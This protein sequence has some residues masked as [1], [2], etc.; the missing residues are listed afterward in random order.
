VSAQTS[1]RASPSPKESPSPRAFREDPS[2]TPPPPDYKAP[3]LLA[4][5]KGLA[6]LFATLGLAFALYCLRPHAGHARAARSP[7]AGSATADSAAPSAAALPPAAQR[8]S[9][10]ASTAATAATAPAAGATA[11]AG[12][13]AAT[14]GNSAATQPIY[15]EALP[16]NA[17]Q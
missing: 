7:A 5:H 1:T 15:I 14:Q 3:S 2:Y 9:T 11:P 12:K 6:I 16:D 4:E 13:S 17:S 8:A 10:G